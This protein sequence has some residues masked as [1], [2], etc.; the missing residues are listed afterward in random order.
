MLEIALHPGL[1]RHQR[2][3]IARDI[4]MDGGKRLHLKVH[5]AVSFYVGRRFG[6]MEDDEQRPTREQHILLVRTTRRDA[7]LRRA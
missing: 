3:L 2:R 6:L 7:R 5:Q 1:D 4:G